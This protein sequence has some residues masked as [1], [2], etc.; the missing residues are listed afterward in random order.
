MSEARP[1][2]VTTTAQIGRVSYVD[3]KPDIREYLINLR[4]DLLRKVKDIDELLSRLPAD[5]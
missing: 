3:D 2:Y 4:R 1:P 5:T